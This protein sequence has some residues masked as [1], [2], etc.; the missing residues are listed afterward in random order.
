M[1]AWGPI[2]AL[3]TA[4]A[5]S[6]GIIF[7][8][9]VG[10]T[11]G[12]VGLNVL[13]NLIALVCFIVTLAFL[14]PSF[15]EVP[16]THYAILLAS[17]ALGIGIAD[18]LFFRALNILGASRAA[19][20]DSV[21][22]PVIALLSYLYLGEPV[23]LLDG[24]GGLLVIGSC[25]LVSVGTTG[26]QLSRARLLEG[27]GL[28]TLAIVLMGIG[29]VGVKPLLELYPVVLTTSTRLVGGIAMLV[30]VTLPSARLRAEVAMALKPQPVWKLAVPGAIVGT[31]VSLM[32]WIAGFKYAPASVAAILN[33]TSTVLIVLMAAVFL[34][35][36]LDGRKLAAVALAFAGCALVLL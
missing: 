27:V 25:V 15:A 2:F 35:E 1:S 24:L 10:Q 34:K 31:F 36:P 26:G 18:T 11:I 3:L 9:R 33:Q 29:I 14:Q 20:F 7:F 21:Y 5:W 19:I 13:K 23:S 8:T 17:G 32:C 22:P 30:I 28:S 4:L 16:A 12:P 6:T